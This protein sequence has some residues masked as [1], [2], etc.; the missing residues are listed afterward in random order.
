MSDS[1][2]DDYLRL[3]LS[4]PG[5]RSQSETSSQTTSSTTTSNAPQR[6]AEDNAMALTMATS[7]YGGMASDLYAH[8][9]VSGQVRKGGFSQSRR[10]VVAE[11]PS[12]RGGAA[13][14][15]ERIEAPYPWAAER[16]A[17]V[18]SLEALRAIGISRIWGEVTCKKC[19]GHQRVEV[20]LEEG[21]SKVSSFFL[22]NRD[23]MHDRAPM[24]W[25]SPRL[26]DC[27]LCQQADC[28]RPI[29]AS[30]KRAINWLFLLLTQTLGLCT[31]EQLKY[32]CKHNRK[33]RTGA[34]DRVLYLTYAGLLKQLYPP[35][36]YDP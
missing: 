2:S 7:Q 6:A 21:F 14:K 5:S 24:L 3:T 17:A 25:Y 12:S 4:P 20:V 13:A 10:S 34:K 22:S 32:F 27:S 19:D 26:L 9:R 18:Q 11:R 36:P 1:E 16:R 30:K 23:S 28:V 35:G 29:V 33:H 15:E 8:Q 31:L